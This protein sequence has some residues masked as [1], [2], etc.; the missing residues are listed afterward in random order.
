MVAEVHQTLGDI[1]LVDARTL[2]Y[3]AAFQDQLMTYTACRS[4]INDTVRILKLSGQVIGVQD[5]R[6]RHCLKTFRTQQADVSV[7][8]RQDTGA[9][10]RSRGYR[11]QVAAPK[12][13]MLRQERNQMLG[14]ADRAYAGT[15]TSVRRRE[16]LMQV[17]VTYIGA[18]RTRICQ[19]NLRV[20]VGAIHIK[21]STASVND[22]AHLLDVHLEDTMRRRI[23]NH[24]GS[25]TLLVLLGFRAEIFQIDI[26]ILVAFNGYGLIPALDSTGRVGSVGGSRKQND[27]TMALAD[28][29]LI[30][31]DHTKTRVLAGGAGVRLQRTALEACDRA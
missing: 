9:T 14:H 10:I 22:L 15:T 30:S 8:D 18:D 17:Q 20:H 25:Q 21:L 28:A 23:G 31:T 11:I 29:F 7:R 27:I 26:T 5:G 1:A 24:A 2:F 4:G 19:S 16:G 13:R 3:R 12:H 6:L